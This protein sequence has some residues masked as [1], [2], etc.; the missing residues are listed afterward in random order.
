MT[1]LM[2]R[3][4][5]FIFAFLIGICIGS[6]LNVVIIRLPRGRSLV[7]PSSRCGVC[8]SSIP[9]WMN[10]P[11]VSF[12]LSGGS[13][14]KCGAPFS[15]RYFWVELLS[16][17]LAMASLS[18]YGFT[19]TALIVFAFVAVLIALS[20]IDFDFRIIPDELSL[21]SWAVVLILVLA[22]FH[23]PEF[24]YPEAFLKMQFGLGAFWQSL[25]ASLIGYGLFWVMSRLFYFIRKEEGLGG[26]DIKLMG[27]VGAM[28][29]L[30]GIIICVLVGSLLGATYGGSRILFARGTRHTAIPFGPFLAFGALVSVLHLD[31]WFW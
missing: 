19:I 11:L 15:A 18:L 13:C 21:G 23:K 17:V 10:L 29:G 28:L 3:D 1:Q 6:F 9:R 7:Q 12:V 8:R 22:G 27:L 26:G 5:E 24:I 4:I 25:I 16:G 20:F 2:P 14:F 30:E 31:R